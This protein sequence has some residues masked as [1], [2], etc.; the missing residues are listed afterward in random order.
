[1]KAMILFAMTLAGL[2]QAHPHKNVPPVKAPL[3]DTAWMHKTQVYRFCIEAP[4]SAG[5][6]GYCDTAV[7]AYFDRH[8]PL[9]F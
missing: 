4:K 8:N 7:S 1:M 9:V 2:L 6:A 5:K 3:R